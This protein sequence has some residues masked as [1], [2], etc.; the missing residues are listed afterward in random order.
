VEAEA[1]LPPPDGGRWTPLLGVAGAAAYA[2]L[3][4]VL[5][6]HAARQPWAVAVLFGPLLLAVG[7]AAWHKRH[8]PSAAAVL[9]GVLGVSWVVA[10]GGVD[11]VNKLYV[12]QHAGI[13]LALALGFAVTLS[14]AAVPVITAVAG[15]LQ[16][17]T[18][19]LQDYTRGLTRLWAL[20][21][22]AV[23]LLSVVLYALAPWPLWSFFANLLTPLSAA[24]LLVGEY[25]V[26][27]RLHPEFERVSLSAAVRAY[28]NP[29]PAP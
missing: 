8:L 1:G 17:M 3:S 22:A 24:A 20:Y 6:V 26:R 14:G 19:G 28:R 2:L 21:F 18:P 10:R 9:A 23:T 25:L 27:Y 16:R 11:D 7:G 5:M 4:H 13:H 15:R 29:P 12:L